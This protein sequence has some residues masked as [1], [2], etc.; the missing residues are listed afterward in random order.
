MA[1]TVDYLKAW[2][3]DAITGPSRTYS[4]LYNA[5]VEYYNLDKNK[6][7]IGEVAL[8]ALQGTAMNALFLISGG[9]AGAAA[10]I[11]VKNALHHHAI[12]SSPEA[13]ITGALTAT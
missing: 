3:R 11:I 4:Q 12:H 6:L 2:T 7:H 10:T 1:T 5:A 8:A 9:L 13:M